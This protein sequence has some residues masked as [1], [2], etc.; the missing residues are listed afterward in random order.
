MPFAGQPQSAGGWRRPG[1]QA[2][3]G[4]FSRPSDQTGQTVQGVF[5]VLLP[6]AEPLGIDDQYPFSGDSPAGNL[7]QSPPGAAGQRTGSGN[8]KTQ[9]NGSGNL[10]DMLSARPGGTNEGLP[11]FA[12]VD[13]DGRCDVDFHLN[14]FQQLIGGRI[15]DGFVEGLQGVGQGIERPRTV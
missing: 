10:V 2:A 6:A 9:L 12:F 4:P 3:P 11:D 5:A 14:I 15:L 7:H 1:R 13:G 8:I